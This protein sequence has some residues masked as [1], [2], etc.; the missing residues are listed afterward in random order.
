MA[1]QQ[2]GV[3]QGGETAGYAVEEAGG[4]EETNIPQIS[5]HHVASEASAIMQEERLYLSWFQTR[6]VRDAEDILRSAVLPILQIPQSL[7]NSSKSSRPNL[8]RMPGKRPI[9]PCLHEP[10]THHEAQIARVSISP[11]VAVMHTANRRRCLRCIP[12]I[13]ITR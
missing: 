13:L 7:F 10:T 5:R 2:D 4:H 11:V 6:C 1:V 9:L 3:Q 12:G 8:I